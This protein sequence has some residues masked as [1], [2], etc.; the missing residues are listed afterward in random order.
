MTESSIDKPGTKAT[1]KQAWTLSKRAYFPVLVAAL[2]PT[3]FSTLMSTK[4]L[5]VSMLSPP[6]LF[7]GTLLIFVVLT[8]LVTVSFIFI[9]S[10]HH[11]DKP[12]SW[13][14]A[15]RYAVRSFGKVFAGALIAGV[16]VVIGFLVF[17]VP[18]VILALFFS[19]YIPVLIFEPKKSIV[20]ALQESFSRVK[21][22][23]WYTVKTLL[24]GFV[25][26]RILLLIVNF[27]FFFLSRLA[28]AFDQEALLISKSVVEFVISALLAPF[29]SAVVMAVYFELTKRAKEKALTEKRL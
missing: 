26:T 18:G 9:A 17:I 23:W 6:T 2:I 3:L 29:M 28:V 4:L 15:V 21:P 20:V 11:Q 22:Y 8:F 7:V 24:A 25:L 12:C 14:L 13:K 1:L 16:I 27:V 10:V 5:P 19:I